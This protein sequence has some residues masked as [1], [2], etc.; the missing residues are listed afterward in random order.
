LQEIL[1]QSQYEP[2]SLEHQVIVIF[3][4]TQGFSDD[5]ALDDMRAWESSLIRFMETSH[6]EIGK[7]IAEKNIISDELREKLV[8][9]LDAFINT[10]Q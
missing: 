2:M 6:P 4:G 1:K 3:A 8:S 9:A 7:E 5:V 10:W